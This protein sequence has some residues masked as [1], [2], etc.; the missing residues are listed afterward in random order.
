QRKKR[1]NGKRSDSKNNKHQTYSYNFEEVKN[2]YRPAFLDPGRKIVFCVSCT[3]KKYYDMTGSIRY[4][5][6]IRKMKANRS[7]DTFES[8]ISPPKTIKLDQYSNYITYL[9]LHIDLF[10][11]PF[12]NFD[13]AKDKFQ[14]Y[15]DRQR[16]ADSMIKI[17][18]NG[19]SKY[20]KSKRKNLKKS[21]SKGKKR[22]P[23]EACLERIR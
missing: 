11:F 14:L 15:Q 1:E 8:L 16:V 4:L 17:I 2:T 10:F 13:T 3:T 9:L 12:Y 18:I 22:N 20:N 21:V 19:S 7:I 5:K 6:K 23:F